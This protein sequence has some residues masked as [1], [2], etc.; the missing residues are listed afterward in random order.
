MRF[1]ASGPTTP[2][3]RGLAAAAPSG[4]RAKPHVR[5]TQ[6]LWQSSEDQ[7]LASRRT[8]CRARGPAPPSR[9][10]RLH[11]RGDHHFFL[12]EALRPGLRGN[13]EAHQRRGDPEATLTRRRWSLRSHFEGAMLHYAKPR[14]RR[15]RKVGGG[16]SI[17]VTLARTVAGASLARLLE[18]RSHGFASLL[19]PRS[20]LARSLEPRSHGL[21]P[22]LE[23]RL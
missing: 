16:C 5:D 13:P 8:S 2:A 14:L 22:L 7:P 20:S 17:I 21:A 11:R 1:C 9:G 18:P 3:S 23:P 12:D 6:E 10:A 19:E 4:T 15:A